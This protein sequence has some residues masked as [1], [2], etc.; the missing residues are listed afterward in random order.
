MN[1][2]YTVIVDK[3]YLQ[4]E[5]VLLISELP[6]VAHIEPLSVE[7]KISEWTQWLPEWII[8]PYVETRCISFIF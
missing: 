6:P 3:Q 2:F 5:T 1:S 8:Y 4:P 7:K